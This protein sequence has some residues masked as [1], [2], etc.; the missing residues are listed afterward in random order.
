MNRPAST[1]AAP[2][3]RSA[4][5]K[6]GTVVLALLV[7]PLLPVLVL[8]KAIEV[9]H[10]LTFMIFGGLSLYFGATGLFVHSWGETAVLA[11]V[12]MLLLVAPVVYVVDRK[13]G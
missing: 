11:L 3:H 12:G 4:L 9:V 5:H 10:L 2:G 6:L 8:F 13:R 1:R 7:L